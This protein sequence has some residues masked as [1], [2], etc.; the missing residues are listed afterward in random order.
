M[1]SLLNTDL[2]W[3]DADTRSETTCLWALMYYLF[4]V[5]QTNMEMA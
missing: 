1:M 2:K 5:V 4:V 3:A